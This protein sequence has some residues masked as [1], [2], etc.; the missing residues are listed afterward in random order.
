MSEKMLNGLRNNLSHTPWYSL[1]PLGKSASNI[2]LMC[3]S[4][5]NFSIDDYDSLKTADSIPFPLNLSTL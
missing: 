4:E 1:P 5:D 3:F 2:D